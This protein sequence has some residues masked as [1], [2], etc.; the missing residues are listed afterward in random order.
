MKRLFKRV[1]TRAG[2]YYAK[3]QYMP[4]GIDWLW[5]IQRV[6]RG[7]RVRTVFD[8]GANVGQTTLATKER[9]AGA[10][11]HAFEPVKAT[12]L[13][14]EQNVAHLAGVTCHR[15]ALSDSVG[16][17]AMTSE[18][19]SQLNRFVDAATASSPSSAVE[20]V[21]TETVDHFCHTLQIQCIDILKVDAE[22]ADLLVLDGAKAMLRSGQIAFV[23][24]EVGFKAGDS[25]HVPFLEIH[26]FLR[27]AGLGIY[28]LYDYYHIEDGRQLL[29]ANALFISPAAIDRM[30]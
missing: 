4:C 13:S 14:L 29:F 24:V 22:G 18:T 12:Y 25:G 5:D 3:R 1:L 16:V 28:G 15:L 10:V 2:I 21:A 23:L 6:A 17:A 27:S 7:R 30:R 19:N 11:V 20:E 8:V 26:E 9:F